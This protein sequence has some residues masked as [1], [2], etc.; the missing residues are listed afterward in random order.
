MGVL[1]SAT[2]AMVAE[3]G[4]IMKEA[5]YTSNPGIIAPPS[6]GGDGGQLSSNP[7]KPIT[8]RQVTAK[9]VRKTN[10]QKTNYTQP[11]T[12]V[13]KPDVSQTSAQKAAPPPVVRA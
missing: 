9:V 2:G 12:D 3:L 13:V 5:G 4:A 7:A 1:G 6:P 11:N 10:L 8:P